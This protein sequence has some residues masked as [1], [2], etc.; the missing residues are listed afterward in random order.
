MQIL[1]LQKESLTYRE[2]VRWSFSD[3]EPSTSVTINNSPIQDF[4]HTDD[5]IPPTN[6]MTPGFKPL[7]H[8]VHVLYQLPDTTC[9][10]DPQEF[11]ATIEK[12]YIDH[13]KKV[14]MPCSFVCYKINESY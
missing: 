13:I 6:E 1:Q 9:K 12:Q 14:E 4:T 5:H 8:V 3:F 10:Q 2:P 7:L 11:P